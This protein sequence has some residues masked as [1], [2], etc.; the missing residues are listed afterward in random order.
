MWAY[1][2]I[3]H[4]VAQVADRKDRKRPDAAA[5]P[6]FPKRPACPVLPKPEAAGLEEDGDGDVANV[7]K[8]QQLARQSAKAEMKANAAAKANEKGQG[9]GRSAGRGKGAG[10]GR[11]RGRGRTSAEATE[12]KQEAPQE[13]AA[14]EPEQEVPQEPGALEPKQEVLEEVQPLLPKAKAGAKGKAKNGKRKLADKENENPD[15]GDAAQKGDSKKKKRV[16]TLLDTVEDLCPSKAFLN[17][18]L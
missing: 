11:G 18:D 6:L 10:R 9:K 2:Y 4:C 16:C 13:A 12:P 5:G 7:L 14:P 15:E 3:Y 17:M 8:M 1:I